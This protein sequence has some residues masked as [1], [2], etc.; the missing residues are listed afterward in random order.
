MASLLDIGPLTEEVEVRGVKLQVQG[1]TAGHL[2]QL[3]AEFPEMRKMVGNKE[4][5]PQEVFLS[6]APELIA[7]IIAMAL[8]KP[9]DQET[10]TKAML[11]GAGDQ[12]NIIMAVQRLTCPDGIGP[13]VDRM[14]ALMTSAIPKTALPSSSKPTTASPA[15]FSASL[16]TDTPA[17]LRGHAR[18]A[19]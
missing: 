18:R 9:R 6:L 1:L 15:P 17:G 13:F 3:I 14:T 10:E 12:L 2:F 8:G 5:S 16:Q 4:G 7:K 19:N 11:M